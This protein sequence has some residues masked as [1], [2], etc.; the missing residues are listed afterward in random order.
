MKKCKIAFTL[1]E[2][3]ITLGVIG[4]VAAITLPII[5]SNIQEH[6]LRNQFK[7]SYSNLLNAMNR[8][9]AENGAPFACGNVSAIYTT[10]ECAQFWTSVFKQFKV[11]DKL[12]SKPKYKTRSE[13]IE[14]GGGSGWAFCTFPLGDGYY[15]ADGSIIYVQYRSAFPIYFALDVNGSNGPNKW[16]YD[17]F[18]MTLDRRNN[19]L[20]LTDDVCAMWEKGGKR[21]NDMLYNK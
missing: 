6:I 5:H 4:V 2:V 11:S 3:L 8:V 7:K 17:L 13:V 9:E 18:Y 14:S 1:A 15:I 16:G 20:N 12:N 10:S 19:K 21:V